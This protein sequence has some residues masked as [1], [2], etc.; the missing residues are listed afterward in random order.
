MCTVKQIQEYSHHKAVVPVNGII[1]LFYYFCSCKCDHVHL[2]V[3]VSA[4]FLSAGENKSYYHLHI[5]VYGQNNYYII[6]YIT[7]IYYVIFSRYQSGEWADTLMTVV[8]TPPIQRSFK[9]LIS[10]I[11]ATKNLKI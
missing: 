1:F 7:G 2:T 10:L 9:R 3:L 5:F 4:V 8:I 6:F 11:V